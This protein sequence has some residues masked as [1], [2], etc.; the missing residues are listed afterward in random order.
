M[1]IDVKNMFA[2]VYTDPM[3]GFTEMNNK[4]QGIG[5]RNLP[6]AVV[7]TNGPLSSLMGR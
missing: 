1:S 2:F 7:D 3:R 6:E 5:G 4:L